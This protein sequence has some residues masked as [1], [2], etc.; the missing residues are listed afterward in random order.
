MVAVFFL[1]IYLFLYILYS[2]LGISISTQAFKYP[3]RMYYLSYGVFVTFL[4]Y[5]FLRLSS[6]NSI[7]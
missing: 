5:L 3:P 7:G 6:Q 1:A 2:G 4:L